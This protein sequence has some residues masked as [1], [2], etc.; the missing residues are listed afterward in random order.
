MRA[1]YPAIL[2]FFPRPGG[3]HDTLKHW[4]QSAAYLRLNRGRLNLVDLASIPAKHQIAVGIVAPKG[5]MLDLY[6]E[7]TPRPSLNE[8]PPFIPKKVNRE[9]SH[10]CVFN[11]ARLRTYQH[12]F[13][14]TTQSL[15]V[16]RRILFSQAHRKLNVINAF[17]MSA[18]RAFSVIESRKRQ[19]LTLVE[20][21]GYTPTG[22]NSVGHLKML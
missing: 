12:I 17:R 4:L 2:G 18:I 13:G 11:S 20:M 15:T 5:R 6:G 21:L 9:G 1:D 14:R 8:F 16:D 3:R 19:A 10:V 22:T 7:Y